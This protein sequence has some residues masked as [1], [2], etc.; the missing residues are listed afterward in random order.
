MIY[1]VFL[2]DKDWKI[3]KIRQCNK[4]LPLSEEEFLTDVVSE[5]EELQNI[6]EDY[7]SM[8]LTFV[9]TELT[10]PAIIRSFKEGNLVI[11]VFIKNNQDF[12]D[13]NNL[14][15]EYVDWAKDC[16][17][18]L[19]HDE[20]YMIQQLNNQLIDA[21]RSL[22]QNNVRLEQALKKNQEMNEKLEEARLSAEKAMR[23]AER[24]NASK[25][26]FLANMSHDI[27]TPMNAIV[28]I[29]GLMQYHLDD[30]GLLKS[31][32]S[33]L[34]SSSQYLLDLI[35][36]I[37]DLSKIENG[38]M[39]LRMEPMNL[40]EQIQQI[41]T[42]IKPQ[43]NGKNQRLIVEKEKLKPGYVMGDP[44]RFRQVL[45]NIF[46][47]AMKYTPEDGTIRFRVRE[48]DGHGEMEAYQ[49]I[50]EDSGM[51]MSEEFVEHIF[52][53]FSRA[54]GSVKGIQGTGLGMAITK[55]I[56]DAMGGNISVYSELGRGSQFKLSFSFQ[57]SEK[58]EQAIKAE[59]KNAVLENGKD[60]ES[61][62]AVSLKGMRFLCAEDNELNAEI[63]T[64][65]L[66]LA[67]ASCVVCGDGKQVADAFAAAAP[68]EYDAI[69]MDVQMPVMNGY[70]ATGKIRGMDREDAKCIPIIAMTA[71]AFQ[72][73]IK[74]SLDTGMDSHIT[75]PLN[76]EE[77][78]GII[79]KV[80]KK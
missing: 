27:R 50:I 70:E 38:S 74:R 26:S 72:E 48:E 80:V 17:F 39:E 47:N 69:L 42:I 61:G 37:L 64:S 54:E 73:D 76:M 60:K 5:K 75:K 33:K 8:D 7:C 16:L 32:I 79:G 2:C 43:I 34:Q 62:G 29:A 41:I 22:M 40:E 65:M 25:T 71:N 59:S 67:E 56:V 9:R 77:L 18:G 13:F 1:A 15:P 10:T 58:P 53:P 28:G 44:V 63:L 68:G 51:G 52:E 57:M 78:F 66:E 11:L 55:S 6:E 30:P 14:Y 45:M 20:Y 12:M 23:R 31:Y 21:Q 35:N 19:Y 4:E 24:A 46:S 3:R 36:D 49:F